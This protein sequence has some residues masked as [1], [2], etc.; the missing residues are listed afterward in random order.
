MVED[1][2]GGETQ[3][4]E[5]TVSRG[6]GG[7]YS[8]CSINTLVTGM[9]VGMEGDVSIDRSALV[10]WRLVVEI[11]VLPSLA[12]DEASLALVN[13]ADGVVAGLVVN[14][15]DVSAPSAFNGPLGTLEASALFL[16]LVALWDSLAW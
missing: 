10:G 9:G 14:P 3:T 5:V 7:R 6:G 11:G 8:V 15:L 1:G 4:T 16:I 12:D 2:D 13:I